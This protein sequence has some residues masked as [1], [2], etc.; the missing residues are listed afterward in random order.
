MQTLEQEAAIITDFYRNK[1]RPILVRQD[2]T[3]QI[4][5]FD[6]LL[7][8]VEQGFTALSP[9]QL[10]FLGESQVGK[11]SLINALL[12]RAALPAGGI[13]PLTAQAIRVRR[14]TDEAFIAAYH[15]AG[16]VNQL[17]FALERWAEQTG[18]L[19]KEATAP[20]KPV[21][22]EEVEEEELAVLDG[23]TNEAG[24]PEVRRNPR[25]EAYAAQA[26]RMFGPHAEPK[27]TLPELIG[28]LRLV[29]GIKMRTGAIARPTWTARIAQI[30]QKL[31]KEDHIR[32]ASLPGRKEFNAE[33]KLRA[34]D[35]LSPLVSRLELRLNQPL[36]EHIELVDL[37]GIGV[38]GDDAAQVAGEFV[39]SKADALA[40][41]VRNNGFTDL[42]AS[43]L[44]SADVLTRRNFDVNG[45]PLFLAVTHLD[46]VARSQHRVLVQNA[47]EEGNAAPSLAEVF[48]GL[49]PEMVQKVRSQLPE[50]LQRSRTFLNSKGP[51]RARWELVIRAI[52]EKAIIHCVSAPDY[53]YEDQGMAKAATGIQA[54][55]EQLLVL[56]RARYER[57]Q[58]ALRAQLQALRGELRSAVARLRGGL[59]EEIHGDTERKRLNAKVDEA[60]M[61]LQ[62]RLSAYQGETQQFLNGTMKEV[63][64]RLCG[65]A[66]QRT[67]EY[68]RQL[69]AYGQSMNV[70]SLQAAMR[71]KG[72]WERREIDFP[73]FLTQH[74]VNQIAQK[75][76]KEILEAIRQHLQMAMHRSHKQVLELIKACPSADAGRSA[77]AREVA[78]GLSIRARSIELWG[79]ERLEQFERAVR[80][81]VHNTV[82]AEFAL[83]CDKAIGLEAHKRAGAKDR[84]LVVFDKAGRE[85]VRTASRNAQALLLKEYGGL[86]AVVDIEVLKPAAN[87]LQQAAAA[88]RPPKPPL[89]EADRVHRA[90]LLAELNVLRSSL[91][92]DVTKEIA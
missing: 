27:P 86:L 60:L 92:A 63:M 42:M 34:A 67:T 85:A 36:L 33:L 88:L 13:G 62:A 44:E 89:T 50:A 22:P 72:I 45:L 64:K 32:Q 55:R 52:S 38:V 5:Q 16:K 46:D 17:R 79:Q 74:F 58:Q 80:V 90:E 28:G 47:R 8:S 1:L 29:L 30:Q 20:V 59:Q 18:V 9:L 83:A 53:L 65:E 12:D 4:V 31:G 6:Q 71:R 11:S 39:R 84:I 61:P 35:W 81:G 24:E 23:A 54:L 14:D 69:V 26:E 78:D 7:K 51:E 76:S 91:P 70:R 82:Y 68:L 19:Q 15:G 25:L 41:V 40:L 21:K 57:Q 66:E 73:G 77:I 75:W 87:P 43:A 37:P 49:R 48:Q 2:D 56:G 3:D 10:G